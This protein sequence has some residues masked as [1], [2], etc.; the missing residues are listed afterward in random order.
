MPEFPLESE[1]TMDVRNISLTGQDVE[2]HQ[3]FALT[4]ECSSSYQ[5]NQGSRDDE[6]SDFS[7]MKIEGASLLAVNKRKNPKPS[8]SSVSESQQKCTTACDASANTTDQK[9]HQ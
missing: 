2:R 1:I 9:P 7:H 4:A 8:L 3:N 6:L 5:G